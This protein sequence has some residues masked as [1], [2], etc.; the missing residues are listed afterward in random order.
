MVAGTMPSRVLYRMQQ[1]DKEIEQHCY[2]MESFAGHRLLRLLT[3]SR[4]RHVGGER[5]FQGLWFGR[6]DLS[7]PRRKRPV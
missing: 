6:R 7:H 2:G 5:V 1:V 4:D 3:T